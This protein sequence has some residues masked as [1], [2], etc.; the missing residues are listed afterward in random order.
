MQFY[1][2]LPDQIDTLCDEK[3]FFSAFVNEPSLEDALNQTTQDALNG[4]Q[5]NLNYDAVQDALLKMVWLD[6]VPCD[7]AGHPDFGTTFIN[8][9]STC[10]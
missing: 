10:H 7:S 3:L 2:P 5:N 4:N 6:T 8:F 1:H 9:G